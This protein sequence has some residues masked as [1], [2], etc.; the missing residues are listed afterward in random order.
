M[1]AQVLA[2]TGLTV[3]AGVSPNRTLSKIAAVSRVAL[4]PTCLTISSADNHLLPHLQDFN[5]PN[6]NYVI[7]P[8]R[9]AMMAF[10]RELSI[11]KIP[12]VGRVTERYLQ[13]L[14]VDKV[15]DIYALRGKLMLVVSASAQPVS[16][17]C[18]PTQL[19][20]RFTAQRG[21][22]RL[23]AAVVPRPGRSRDR[24]ARPTGP[25]RHRRRAHLQR[26]L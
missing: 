22:H 25:E 15:G 21:S 26:D 2:E 10:A 8:T 6:G 5:K 17:S 16:M 3:S 11:R 14:G 24:R 1:R 19:T 7:E 9:E 18:C 13:A 20:G 23:S 12:G 4:P